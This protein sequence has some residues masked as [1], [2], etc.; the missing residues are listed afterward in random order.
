MPKLKVRV[1][2]KVARYGG[3]FTD[4]IQGVM[5]GSEPVE[6]E[7]TPL[8]MRWLSSG[9]IVKVEEDRERKQGRDWPSDLRADIVEILE[10]F[11][12]TPE[13]VEKASDEE[14]LSI[15]G[16]GEGKLRLIR[17]AFGKE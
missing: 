5:I 6:V 12:F 3:V 8:V 16:I 7:L 9:Q 2:D 17:E 15:K 11:G 14:L 13:D 1:S 10:T 4:Y